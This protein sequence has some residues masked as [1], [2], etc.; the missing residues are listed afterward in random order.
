M[1]FFGM[2]HVLPKRSILPSFQ[3][4]LGHL[5]DETCQGQKESCSHTSK[6]PSNHRFVLGERIERSLYGLLETLIAAKHYPG[7]KVGQAF[8][9][10]KAQ[11]QAGKPDLHAFLSCR[12][13]IPRTDGGSWKTQT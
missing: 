8:Q 5:A 10:D 11:S 12:G 1:S 4:V 13:N 2:Q 9:P 6:F 7:K 3:R